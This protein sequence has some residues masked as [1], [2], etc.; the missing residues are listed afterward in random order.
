MKKLFLTAAV[1]FTFG[2]ANAQEGGFKTG[3]HL[4]LPIGDIQN[5]YSFAGGVDLAYTWEVADKIV[6]GATT[7]YTYYSGKS[8]SG[9]TISAA[10]LIPIAA[11]AQYSI[12][13]NFFVGADLGFAL[14]SSTSGAGSSNGVYYQPKFGYQTEKIEL[15]A[16]YKAAAISGGSFSTVGIGFNYKY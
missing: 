15:Y 10:G 4:G 13:D 14:V 12:N 7:G 9:F 16:G 1:L 6:V 2:F 8:V 5:A 3:L 11:T